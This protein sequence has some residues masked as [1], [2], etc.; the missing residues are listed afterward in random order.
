MSSFG[1]LRSGS[2]SENFQFSISEAE[3]NEILGDISVRRRQHKRAQVL[4]RKSLS[5]YQYF[6]QRK[7]GLFTAPLSY[8]NAT[9]NANAKG[10][11]QQKLLSFRSGSA[12]F[13]AARLK[14]K[15]CL[16]QLKI[17]PKDH[18]SVIREL[19]TIP[20]KCADVKIHLLLGNLY[21]ASNLRRLAIKYFKEALQIFPSSTEIVD[22]LLSMGVDSAEVSST[23][24]EGFKA[25]QVATDALEEIP[26]GGWMKVYVIATASKRDFDM[27]TSI[28][29]WKKLMEAFPKNAFLMKRTAASLLLSAPLT[30][31]TLTSET[32]ATARSAAGKP[33]FGGFAISSNE[34]V[35]AQQLL[36][37]V[38]RDDAL[39]LDGMDLL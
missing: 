32:I 5:C 13:D 3:I 6:C 23:T 29:C 10:K 35:A 38:R 28:S 18:A 24:D 19:E 9:A 20:H 4:F 34:I 25:K 31:S 22:A 33:H 14:Y 39:T 26:S 27:E 7:D 12:L 30:L 8:G 1:E 16:C 21:K 17:N 2:E 11:N 36:S 37:Q 15:I